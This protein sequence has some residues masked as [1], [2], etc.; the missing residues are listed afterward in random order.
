MQK[1]LNKLTKILA[2]L[3]IV[4]GSGAVAASVHDSGSEADAQWKNA[5]STNTHAAYVAFALDHPDSPMVN[6]ALQRLE[7]TGAGSLERIIQERELAES[8]DDTQDQFR[9]FNPNSIIVI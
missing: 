8:A 2:T 6:K 7:K 3:P 5:E 9:L 4:I 1:L